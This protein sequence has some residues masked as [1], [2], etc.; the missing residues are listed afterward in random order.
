MA[1]A[2]ERLGVALADRYTIERELGRGGMAVVY[3][4]NDVKHD[5]Q[6]AVKVFLP[7]LAAALGTD[8]FFREIKITANLGHPHILPLLDSGEAD[9]FL[10]CAMPYVAG[11]SLRVRLE[12]EKQLP[13]DDALRIARDSEVRHHRVTR[14]QQDVLRLDVAVDHALGMRI[15][16]CIRHLPRDP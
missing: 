14:L 7:E 12:K 6:V 15:R 13:L 11:E 10:Y 2:P 5:R 8:R 4:A 3:L 1:D 16:Q 9:G